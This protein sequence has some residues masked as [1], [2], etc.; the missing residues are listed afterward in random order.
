MRRFSVAALSLALLLAAAWH[1]NADE[2]ADVLLNQVE[3]AISAANPVLAD[4]TITYTYQ[5]N[6]WVEECRVIQQDGLSRSVSRT[7]AE[8]NPIPHDRLPH[9]AYQ[10]DPLLSRF[11]AVDRQKL[12]LRYAGNE[13]EGD[14]L[15]KIIEVSFPVPRRLRQD[16]APNSTEFVTEKW[17]VGIDSM[18]HRMTGDVKL[19]LD[20]KEQEAKVV[21][22]E[23]RVTSIRKPKELKIA[24]N[25]AVKPVQTLEGLD[26]NT[27]LSDAFSPDGKMLAF[28][29]YEGGVRVWETTQWRH[30]PLFVKHKSLVQCVA[31]SP[32]SKLL[33]TASNDKTVA[34]SDI[35]QGL[36]VR[37]LEHQAPV[38]A[39]A[40]SPD[41]KR[42]A[43]ADKAIHIWNVATGKQERTWAGHAGT[44]ITGLAFSPD[45]KLLAS[46]GWDNTAKLWDTA[47]WQEART[48][49]GYSEPVFSVRFSPDGE[50]LATT[51]RDGRV[52][53]WD[54]ETG[55]LLH[56]LKDEDGPVLSI[57]FAHKGRALAAAYEDRLAKEG[58]PHPGVKFWDTTTWQSRH[59]LTSDNLQLSF[60][61]VSPDDSLLLTGGWA[62]NARLFAMPA[63][64]AAKR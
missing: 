56:T 4:F 27:F 58:R 2:R 51:S 49:G 18:I 42:I 47:T 57:A 21:H 44:D 29:S 36:T 50:M 23:V 48:L 11:D 35:S 20:D 60:V 54:P 7:Y 22:I 38:C 17:Y 25:S 63:L 43:T 53:V 19:I 12:T 34:L 6:R 64:P 26:E 30:V 45:G 62:N 32:D 41:G 37:V 28:G 13:T 52:K 15:Y 31:F 8:E 5:G 9:I 10:F 14:T 33:A 59:T 40:F 24:P 55:V 3:D 16:P 1:A 61:A 39:L 46:C